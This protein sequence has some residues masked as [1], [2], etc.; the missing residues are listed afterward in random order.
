MRNFVLTTILALCFSFGLAQIS[1][2][3]CGGGPTVF[4]CGTNAPNP[5]PNGI[6]QSGSLLNLTVQVLD[7]AGIDVTSTNVDCINTGD[8]EDVITIDGG[9]LTCDEGSG[10]NNGVD[11]EDGIDIITVTDSTIDARDVLD[12]G[13]GSDVI[14]AER[15]TLI[16]RDDCVDGD[17]GDDVVNFTDVTCF[18]GFEGFELASGADTVNIVRSQILCGI[19]EDCQESIEASLD[20]DTII[21]SESILEGEID[22]GSDDDTLRL[23][24]G[25]D[26]RGLIDCGPGIDTIIFEMQVPTS[27]LEEITAE[28]E[29]KNPDAGS[30]TI[31]R[32]NYEWD[33]CNVLIPQLQPGFISPVPTLSEW[34]LIAM[35]AILGIVGFI[36]Y[37]RRRFT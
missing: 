24:T 11:A 21:I 12:G 17:S 1:F 13:P 25:S 37:Q 15:T 28:I 2:A 31:N 20:D 36:F 10:G 4:T 8:G 14:T 9:D 34:G 35:A 32:L 27:R 6:Q 23:G 3:A 30:I 19:P 33:R 16:A 5:D 18:Y 29:S 7:G 22:L 26:I